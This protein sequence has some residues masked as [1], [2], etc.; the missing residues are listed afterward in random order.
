MDAQQ[1][2][3]FLMTHG[4]YFESHQLPQVKSLLL[5]ATDQQF[6]RA[7]F[8]EYK[9]PTT[10]LILSIFVGVLGIDRFLIGDTGLGVGKLLICGGLYIWWIVDIFLISGVTREKNLIRLQ[11]SLNGY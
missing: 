7:Q 11:Q 2:D 9:D 10:M 5:N 4:K 6:Q 1:V 3:M 8:S